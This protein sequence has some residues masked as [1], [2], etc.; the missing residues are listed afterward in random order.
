MGTKHSTW[1]HR[2]SKINPD[3]R[4]ATCA[5][6]GPVRIRKHRVGWRCGTAAQTYNKAYN[7]EHRRLY[8]PWPSER[9]RGRP[10]HG[11]LSHGLGEPELLSM[12]AEQNSRCACCG[13]D[14]LKDNDWQ[15]DHDHE[16]NEVRALLC[17]RCNTGLGWF[18]DSP[19]F[20]RQ[21][22]TYLRRYGV[23]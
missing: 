8:G 4:T 21:A 3:S 18:R 5:H 6:C 11:R 10:H 15:V 1:I 9:G 2:L 14:F 20:L 13:Q 17:R 12:L 22:I 19:R 16:T 7:E 23:R